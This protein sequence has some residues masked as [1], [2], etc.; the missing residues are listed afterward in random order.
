MKENREIELPKWN[1]QKEKES[2]KESTAFAASKAAAKAAFDYVKSLNLR[3]DTHPSFK[4]YSPKEQLDIAHS[5]L[6]TRLDV[7]ETRRSSGGIIATEQLIKEGIDN[8]VGNCYTQ[9]HLALDHIARNYPDDRAEVFHFPEEIDHVNAVVNRDPNS[10]PKHPSTWGENCFI[11][12]TWADSDVV[13][14]SEF[15]KGRDY[16]RNKYKV[17]AL[18][19][20]LINKEAKST[21]DPKQH[22]MTAGISSEFIRQGSNEQFNKEA[23]E[24]LDTLSTGIGS[25]INELQSEKQSSIRDEQIR[26]LKS[27]LDEIEAVRNTIKIDPPRYASDY[28]DK[29]HDL[30]EQINDVASFSDK[31]R[32]TLD[33]KQS[34]VVD[35]LQTMC[36]M[37]S[38][39]TTFGELDERMQI[40]RR[41]IPTSSSDPSFNPANQGIDFTPMEKHLSELN[42]L[43]NKL[44]DKSPN[45]AN[46]ADDANVVTPDNN[47]VTTDLDTTT[48]IDNE[49]N[50]QLTSEPPNST[51]LESASSGLTP[52]TNTSETG[53]SPMEPT[54]PIDSQQPTTSDLMSSLPE[55]PTNDINNHQ[56]EENI[57]SPLNSSPMS[58]P[59]P[60]IQDAPGLGGIPNTPTTTPSANSSDLMSLLPEAPNHDIN[61]ISAFPQAPDHEISPR[62]ANSE[63]VDTPRQAMPG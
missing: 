37:G 4:D 42:N 26:T 54:T 14:A 30:V 8:K 5:Q 52:L 61:P 47:P 34:S 16:T 33:T 36:G 20:C 11:C 28:A 12:D 56:Y 41:K 31:D 57:L 35:R 21:Y 18:N 60:S 43:R 44:A 27:K 3:S 51:E 39:P 7:E 29:R 40:A 15:A 62:S 6:K 1:P 46:Q 19:D 2:T 50:S 58:N 32:Q 55:A 24:A 10:D 45:N 9:A 63:Q 13:P 49:T 48:R 38:K 17:D 23:K 59:A 22:E 25:S 53:L